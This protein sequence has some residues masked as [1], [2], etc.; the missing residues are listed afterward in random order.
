MSHPEIEV[1]RSLAFR[2]RD[3]APPNDDRMAEILESAADEIEGAAGELAAEPLP[4]EMDLAR[5][6]LHEILT[7]VARND[8]RP[9]D[10]AETLARLM[11]PDA[12]RG[13]AA[14]Q[15]ESEG[16]E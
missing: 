5:T 3:A 16:A 2:L 4:E 6:R 7:E 12:I 9:W 15:R 11:T 13:L 8:W 1:L 14:E 10:C